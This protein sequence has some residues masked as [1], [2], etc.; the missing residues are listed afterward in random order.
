MSVPVR[1]EVTVK[2]KAE[3]VSAYAEELQKQKLTPERAEELAV[4][5]GAINATVLDAA[6]QGFGFFDEPSHFLAV[7]ESK[8]E[9]FQ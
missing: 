3:T 5:A 9:T 7:L 4:E 2:V 8:A 6:T 1:Q